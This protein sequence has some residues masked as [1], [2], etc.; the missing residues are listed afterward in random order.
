MSEKSLT[1]LEIQVDLTLALTGTQTNENKNRID[2][3][4]SDSMEVC[5]EMKPKQTHYVCLHCIYIWSE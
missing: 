2:G 4:A 5:G 3:P 1:E